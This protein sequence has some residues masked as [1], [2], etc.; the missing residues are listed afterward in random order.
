MIPAAELYLKTNKKKSIKVL[1]SKVGD[2]HFNWYI[3]I[4]KPRSIKL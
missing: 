2:E 4:I 3:Y 1:M